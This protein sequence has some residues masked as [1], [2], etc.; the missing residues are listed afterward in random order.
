MDERG[1]DLELSLTHHGVPI[2]PQLAPEHLV[3]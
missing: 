1:D 3:A 2:T